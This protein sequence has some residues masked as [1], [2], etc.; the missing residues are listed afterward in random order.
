MASPRT[1]RDQV[2]CFSGKAQKSA[3]GE[4]EGQVDRRLYFYRQKDPDGRV[5]NK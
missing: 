1:A 3:D 2:I 5:M 4:R